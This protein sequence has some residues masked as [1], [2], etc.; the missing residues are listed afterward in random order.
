MPSVQSFV[1]S[2]FAAIS[3]NLPIKGKPIFLLILVLIIFYHLVS[4]TSDHCSMIESLSLSD[5][6]CTSG[7]GKGSG[8]FQRRQIETFS[9]SQSYF[10][11]NRI[12]WLDIR[13]LE[14]FRT[15]QSNSPHG[16]CKEIFVI[17]AGKTLTGWKIIT[18]NLKQIVLPR[19]FTV[20]AVNRT[21][22]SR[23][24][25]HRHS[26]VYLPELKPE[27]SYSDWKLR[28]VP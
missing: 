21:F 8:N 25:L 23:T 16:F 5:N 22:N 6:L 9:V 19:L 18:K 15:S 20:T 26:Q 24:L 1:P 17:K 3:A 14:S 11:H 13:T 2:H 28:A 4:R 12:F 27:F 7:S 10:N